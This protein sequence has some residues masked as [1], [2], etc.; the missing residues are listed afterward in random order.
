MHTPFP[1]GLRSAESPLK[2]DACP[3]PSPSSR[4]PSTSGW[5]GALSRL[6]EGLWLLGVGRDLLVKSP[7]LAMVELAPAVGTP[8][9][10]VSSPL[11][12]PPPAQLFGRSWKLVELLSYKNLG[13][14]RFQFPS[15]VLEAQSQ[16]GVPCLWEGPAPSSSWEG[17][18]RLDLRQG[19]EEVSQGR[20]GLPGG[21][22]PLPGAGP[23]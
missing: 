13:V 17:P 11:G 4:K 2:V 16:G 7:G 6:L 20:T 19:T 3:D 21:F 18:S 10:G 15:G 12:S 22:G 14:R 5:A 8:G 23:R 1:G 9:L